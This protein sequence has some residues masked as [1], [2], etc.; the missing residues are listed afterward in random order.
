MKRLKDI[1]AAKGV[2][3]DDKQGGSHTKILFGGKSIT[4]V[5]RHNEINEITAKNIIKQ[6]KDA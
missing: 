4:T 2:E 6:A 1:A 3:F 5:P